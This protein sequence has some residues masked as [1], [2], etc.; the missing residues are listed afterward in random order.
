MS[1]EYQ[2][3]NNCAPVSVMMVLSYYGITVTQD[4]ASNALRPNKDSKHVE[5]AQ[6]VNYLA[7]FGL[8]SLPR[9]AGDPERLKT[10]L[11]NGIP[12]LVPQWLHE[13]EDIGHYRLVRGYDDAKGVVIMNDAY[14]GPDYT[15]T[16]EQFDALWRGFN[17]RYI[18]VYRPAD[19]PLVKAILGD[20][21]NDAVMY[22]RAV[23][24]AQSESNANPGSLDGWLML[25]QSY[26]GAG[27]YEAATKAWERA[28]KIGIPSRLLWYQ[29]WPVIAYNKIGDYQ[30]VLD[31]TNQVLSN[32][33]V[34]GELRV[35][36]GK[37]LLAL[38][39]VEEARAQFEQALLDDSTLDSA[40]ELLASLGAE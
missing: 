9:E 26:F 18:P 5:P 15:L 27:D 6:I 31:M 35:E 20:D 36:R 39:Q 28:E 1:F 40:R 2:K 25:G 3:W 38:G 4:E 33:P 14:M 13:G 22:G 32:M 12:V 16:W 34:Y 11:A 30:R 7:T 19:E 24:L 8:K 37:A 29:D 17:R 23:T 10:L 21:M